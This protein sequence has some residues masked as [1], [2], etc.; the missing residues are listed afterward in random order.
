MPTLRVRGG[1]VYIMNKRFGMQRS[2]CVYFLVAGILSFVSAFPAFA[3]DP[4]SYTYGGINY[5]LYP[6]VED[7]R[8]D[9]Y[10]DSYDGTTADVILPLEFEYNG[11]MC[12]VRTDDI[13][14]EIFAGQA[15]IVTLKADF[16]KENFS[17]RG[18]KNLTTV[19]FP[20]EVDRIG[21]YQFY[22]CPAIDFVS[23]LKRISNIGDYAFA[24]SE[25]TEL[26]LWDFTDVP[27]VSSTIFSN[28]LYTSLSLDYDE[29]NMDTNIVLFDMLDLSKVKTLKCRNMEYLSVSASE[30]P[31][32]ET[33]DITD[34]G[35]FSCNEIPKNL[36]EIKLS[37]SFKNIGI[38]SY[39]IDDS[40]PAVKLDFEGVTKIEQDLTLRNLKFG[41]AMFELPEVGGNLEIRHLSG[42]KTLNICG[43]IS[44]AG[45]YDMPDLVSVN[46]DGMKAGRI[47]DNP[48][49]ERIS[50]P[51]VEEIGSSAFM[52]NASL[53]ELYVGDKL[54]K[55]DND[56]ILDGC[57]AVQDFIYGGTIQ[58][59]IAIEQNYTSGYDSDALLYNV[60][61]FWYGHGD[62][63]LTKLTELNSEHLMGVEVI[64]SGSFAGYKG[65]TK[66]IVPST[67]GEI[68]LRAFANCNGIKDIDL[69]CGVIRQGAFYG[70]YSI[71][72]MTFR[73]DVK[74]IESA[75]PTKPTTYPTVYYYGTP[76]RWNAIVKGSFAYNKEM[77]FNG[78]KYADIELHCPEVVGN[79]FQYSQWLNTMTIECGQDT[80]NI[81]E[82]AF[83][84]SSIK[85][86]GYVPGTGSRSAGTGCFVIGKNAF[87]SCGNLTDIDIFDNAVSIGA[88]ALEGTAWLNAQQGPS[89]LYINLLNGKT[90]Y[91]YLGTAPE[92]TSIEVE[93]GTV[94]IL[95]S[96]F[97]WQ[98]GITAI[99][100]PS[101]LKS[102]GEG[103]FT[104]TNITKLVIPA[105]VEKASGSLLY[106]VE[107]FIIEDSPIALVD[108]G[109]ARFD[110]SNAK[111]IYY[112]RDMNK[113]GV[114]ASGASDLS[115]TYGKYV[116]VV[117][118]E[119]YIPAAT[120]EVHALA[121]VPPTC[122]TET[123][124][125][126]D[127]TYFTG[128]RSVDFDKCVLYVPELSLDDYRKAEGWNQ[129]KNIQADQSGV[130]NVESDG[131]DIQ[132]EIYDLNGRR[133]NANDLTPGLYIKHSVNKT[134]KILV[135]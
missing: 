63:K 20:E 62:A 24:M 72:N 80:I 105:S 88:G 85:K 34:C 89:T 95:P 23:F 59:W 87:K 68:E 93:E 35:Y 42:V 111:K 100:L 77:Y 17:F 51:D 22:D 53:K 31:A 28:R 81:A 113:I 131:N 83:E 110:L 2:S 119:N 49:L 127:T 9:A 16:W 38:E 48:L 97:W 11:G 10:V 43:I 58:Q 114:S 3:Q 39:E 21:E 33:A 61:N 122:E 112:G 75:F 40:T 125:I 124:W 102:I 52:R 70:C 74:E 57:S 25:P 123:D 46:A 15:N 73:S 76:D 132:A 82:S 90:V 126:Y 108:N 14:P 96:A 41:S 54:K 13:D 32:L 1:V 115:V 66:V 133:R 18:C 107:E 94:D 129:F 79:G 26:P 134:E 78:T 92:N 4:V 67:V 65:L 130:E 64:K 84:G 30:F 45:I 116:T 120:T 6:P 118:Q 8:G 47:Q 27:Y 117:N 12:S 55:Y 71:E 29:P 103:A 135:K 101:T 7:Y 69:N 98:E 86:I 106:K 99:T 36:A 128:L 56:Q 37:G 5:R 50:L 104:G 109:T 121:T 91:K 19:T 44:E 60:P